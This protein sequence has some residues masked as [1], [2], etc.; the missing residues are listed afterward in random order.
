[1]STFPFF[2]VF[3]PRRKMA[4]APHFVG[5]AGERWRRKIPFSEHFILLELASS[6][7]SLTPGQGDANF[8]PTPLM[9]FFSFKKISL[10]II[11]CIPASSPPNPAQ[12]PSSTLIIKLW[13][14]FPF[15]HLRYSSPVWV[16]II[17]IAFLLL[18]VKNQLK[19]C[20]KNNFLSPNLL[21]VL[22]GEPLTRTAVVCFLYIFV[23]C[24]KG[25]S[26][27][28]RNRRPLAVMIFWWPFDFGL[29]LSANVRTTD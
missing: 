29:F 11:H 12:A 7:S 14:S 5:E 8:S 19:T 17:I 1:M 15:P 13:F 3:Y 26:L 22:G 25:G 27:F 2:L 9:K 20:F 28:Q 23:R 18:I 4:N 10:I 24:R 6:C 16:I 21:P